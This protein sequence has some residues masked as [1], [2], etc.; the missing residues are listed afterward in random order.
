MRVFV[1]GGTGFI[2]SVVVKKLIAAGHQVVALS[3]SDTSGQALEATG[4]EPLY[5]TVQDMDVLR[6]GAR[7]ADS[8]IHMAFRNDFDHY[9]EAVAEDLAAVR[10]IGS[11]LVGSGK[12]FVITSG[13]LMVPSLGR[14]ATEKDEGVM[15]TPRV[16]AE[17]EA[18]ELSHHGVRSSVVR[19]A[20]CVHNRERQGIASILCQIARD[21]KVSAYCGDGQNRWPAVYLDDAAD[22]FCKAMESAPAGT[23]LHAVGEEAIPLKAVA[24]AIGHAL[25]IPVTSLSGEEAQ[26]HFGWFAGALS[27]DNPT[28]SDFTQKTL[29]WCP[30]TRSLI[31]DIEAFLSE[32]SKHGKQRDDN[33]ESHSVS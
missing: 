11:S 4:A 9:D 1:T 16:A 13:T 25:G 10:E 14:F 20:P 18:I 27:L 32:K 33:D 31:D 21:K 2:G 7:G 3:R 5:G 28:S 24:E 29:S 8:V 12:P 23:R 22:L 17:R 15:A 6:R 19:L 30:S 26:Q